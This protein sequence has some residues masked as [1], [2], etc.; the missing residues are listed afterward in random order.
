MHTEPFILGEDIKVMCIEA[1]LFPD[2][3]MAAHQQLHELVPYSTERKYYGLSRPAEDGIIVY[4]AA[5]SELENGEAEKLQLETFIIK[6]GNY[7]SIAIHNYM[8]DIPTIGKAF[9]ELIARPDIDPNGLCVEWYLNDK[10]VKC[11]VRLA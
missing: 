9:S 10:D 3:V 8:Q 4:K 11:M 6:K 2:G 1:S 5:A 7:V